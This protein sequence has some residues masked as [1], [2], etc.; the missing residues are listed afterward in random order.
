VTLYVAPVVE[1]HT[2]QDFLAPFLYRVWQQLLGRSEQLLVLEPWRGKRAELAHTNGVAL[3]N[4][5]QKSFAKLGAK[6][7]HDPNAL[8]LLLVL[9]DADDDCPAQLAPRLLETATAALPAGAP[10][11]CV[12]AKKMFENWIVAGA[13]ALAGVSGLPTPLPTLADP[14][15][16]S[17]A[18]WLDA[19][20]RT[21]N[22]TRKY[23]K[24]VDAKDLVSAMN[25]TDC[26]TSSPSFDKLCRELAKRLPPPPPS[27]EPPSATEPEAPAPSE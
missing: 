1:G 23:K 20:F 16:C 2:E 21:K 27:E 3:S 6:T 24:T 13:S 9:L 25:L 14:E 8:P 5:V 18:G 17:G 11:A 7:K 12:L 19:Q 10:V 26:R 22:K 4:A 15:G